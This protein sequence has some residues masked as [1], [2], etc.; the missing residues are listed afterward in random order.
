MAAVRHLE[1]KKNLRD[2]H[3]AP[4]LLLQYDTSRSHDFSSRMRFYDF[5]M[6]DLRHLDF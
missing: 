6:A 3:R 5:K 4:N 1:F 2:C